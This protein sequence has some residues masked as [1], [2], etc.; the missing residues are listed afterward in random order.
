M[1]E[2]RQLKGII[3]DLDGVLADTEYYQWQGWV[4][5]LKPY[6]ILLSKEKYFDY[7]GKREDIIEKELI[8]KYNLKIK[9]GELLD[10]REKLLIEWFSSKKLKPMPWVKEAVVFFAKEKKIKLAIAS[11][12][13]KDEVILK[14]KKINFYS[15]FPVIVAGS[16]VKRGKPYPDIY[17]LATKKLKLKPKECLALEDTQYG[18][19]SAKTAGLVCFAIPSEYSKKQ[20]FS[21][22]NK[23][24][25][26]LKEVIEWFK[27]SYVRFI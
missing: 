13:P 12:G 7:A 3:F 9:K 27:N 26:S 5:A 18:T 1:S 19:E 6:G 21:K 22:A 14:L 17:L 10:K 11:S 25:P 20:N 24:F 23:I 15:Y 16:E 2:L 8:K 4:E